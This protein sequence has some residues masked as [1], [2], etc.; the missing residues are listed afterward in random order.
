M[1]PG[2]GPTLLTTGPPRALL[3][4]MLGKN[5]QE[6]MSPYLLLFPVPLLHGFD[7]FAVVQL[8]MLL[9][10]LQLLERLDGVDLLQVLGAQDPHSVGNRFVGVG[11]ELDKTIALNTMVNL[12][13]STSQTAHLLPCSPHR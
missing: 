7:V 5:I 12:F 11:Q 9:A 8:E 10:V 13:S 3:R 2:P 1:N 6:K 4:I